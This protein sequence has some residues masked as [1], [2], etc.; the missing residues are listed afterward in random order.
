MKNL[1]LIAG[2]MMS[3]LAFATMHFEKNQKCSECHPK[4]YEEYKTS[5][6]GNSTVFADPIHGAVYDLHP[7]KNKMQKYRCAK[8]H[9]PTADNLQALLTKNNGVNS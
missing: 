7:Q 9:T 1:F 8:C 5:Q 6:H 2:L 3:T 4:I